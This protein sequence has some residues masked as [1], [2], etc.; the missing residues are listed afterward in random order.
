MH[1]KI[2]GLRIKKAPLDFKDIMTLS[3]TQEREIL[4]LH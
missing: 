4:R 2:K 1:D 3:H